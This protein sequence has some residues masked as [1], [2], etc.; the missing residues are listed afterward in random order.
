VV[1]LPLWRPDGPVREDW[2][3][4]WLEGGVAFKR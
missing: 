2:D 1:Q 3:T 4:I